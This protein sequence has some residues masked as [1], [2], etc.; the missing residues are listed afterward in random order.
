MTVN[1]DNLDWP[2]RLRDR[3]SR[4]GRTVQVFA[5]VTEEDEA[6]GESAAYLRATARAASAKPPGLTSARWVL[7]LGVA[8]C[9][10]AVA[11]L[12]TRNRGA[13]SSDRATVAG[14]ASPGPGGI[15]APMASPDPTSE[16]QPPAHPAPHPLPPVLPVTRVALTPSLA[17]VPVGA[18]DLAGEAL[19][20]LS[21]GGLA[22]ASAQAASTEIALAR[23]SLALSVAHRPPGSSLTVRSGPYLFRVVGTRFTVSR[24]LAQVELVVD[25]G[26]VAVWRGSKRLSITHA[27]ERWTAL[28]GEQGLA[29]WRASHIDDE[30][31]PRRDQ[32]ADPRISLPGPAANP[33]LAT[34]PPPVVQPVVPSVV[35]PMPVA[36]PALVRPA[37]VASA[38]PSPEVASAAGTACA[39][40]AARKQAREALRCYQSQAAQGGLAGETALYQSARLW[41]D[42]LGDPERALAFLQEQ[43]TRFPGGALRAEADL[44]I[45]ELLPRVGRHADAMT[46]T[47]R[48][49][50]A[51]P[52][53]LHRGEI[54]LLRGNILREV[55]RD[56]AA[57]ER[58]YIQGGDA[59]GPA[60]D[61]CR[62][63]R[64]VCLEALG[65]TAEA[66]SAYHTYLATGTPAHRSEAKS[67][68][69]H[70]VP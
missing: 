20:T 12:A 42:A 55:R 50:A 47:S 35:Q 27:G 51:H 70:L 14:V 53:D 10:T 56:L 16:A 24:T 59:P 13:P 64:A 15:S 69:D 5:A 7:L 36:A 62:F 52:N 38:G 46:E 43:R 58:E 28:L 45:I 25:E 3:H 48:F 67:R 6:E 9:A 2:S 37:P 66:R 54:R 60:G 49:L 32:Q 22:R 68:L 1:P 30:P 33:A 21:E 40:L 44:S 19:G 29:T 31:S 17:Q 8:G 34:A 4:L 26:A 11:V 41:R 63:L 23:G 65:R 18:F 39:Q 61:E 57:A